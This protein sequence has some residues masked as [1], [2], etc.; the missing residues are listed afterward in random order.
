MHCS[1][2]LIAD[3]TRPVGNVCPIRPKMEKY[4]K[5]PIVYT[6]KDLNKGYEDDGRIWAMYNKRVYDL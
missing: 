5:G 4:H 6:M 1:S 2:K 3:P